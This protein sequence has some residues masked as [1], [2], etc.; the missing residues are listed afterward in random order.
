MVS[1]FYLLVPPLRDFVRRG[2]DPV[3]RTVDHDISDTTKYRPFQEGSWYPSYTFSTTQAPLTMGWEQA[4]QT[5]GMQSLFKDILYLYPLEQRQSTADPTS[6]TDI[7]R[8]LVLCAWTAR[9]RVVEAQVMQKQYEMSVG[10][11]ATDFHAATW[12]DH[13][14]TL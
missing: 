8:R 11:T 12:L 2:G 14:W 13:S 1:A 9:L 10:E 3:P 7:C 5:P 6:C 4:E